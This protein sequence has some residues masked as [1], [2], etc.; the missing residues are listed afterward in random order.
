MLGVTVKS[1]GNH[2]VSPGEEKER[3]QSEGLQKKQD[4]SLE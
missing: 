2:V 1:L 3:L 4:L